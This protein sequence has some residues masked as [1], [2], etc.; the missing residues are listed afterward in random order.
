MLYEIGQ[1]VE[2]VN[3]GETY[4]TYKEIFEKLGFRNRIE[5]S[6]FENGEI[7]QIFNVTMHPVT[8]ATMLAL[9]NK[10]GKECLIGH[11]GVRLLKFE[12]IKSCFVKISADYTAEVTQTQMTVGCQKINKND[13]LALINAAKEIGFIS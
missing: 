10:N 5:N 1:V 7:A 6:G 3:P 13:F 4:P 11:N 2:I 9:V 12:R 8:G